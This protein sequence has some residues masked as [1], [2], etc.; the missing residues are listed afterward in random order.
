MNGIKQLN[1]EYFISKAR[2]KLKQHTCEGCDADGG[3]P[4]DTKLVPQNRWVSGTDNI[5]VFVEAACS[6]CGEW[7]IIEEWI[8]NYHTGVVLDSAQ[9][10]KADDEGTHQWRYKS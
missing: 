7:N 6:H 8:C 9:Q 2:K 3:F 1:Q 4:P 10:D 5:S